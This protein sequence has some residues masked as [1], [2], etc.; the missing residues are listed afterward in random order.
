MVLLGLDASLDLADPSLV[1]GKQF[2][3]NLTAFKSDVGDVLLPIA[4]FT[5]TPGT[6]VSTEGRVQSFHAAVRPLGEARPAWK[7][8]RVLG[9]MLGLPGF[10]FETIEQVREACLGGRDIQGL[11][12]N[13]IDFDSRQQQGMISAGIQRVADVPIYFADPLARRSPPLQKTRDAQA[14]RAWMNSRLLQ[15]LGVQ[16]GGLVLVKQ[17]GG[18]AGLAAALDD[19]LP[20]DCVRIAAGHPS[21]AA[22]GA[23]FAALTLEKITSRQAA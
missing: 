14:P 4:P 7:V 3:V 9:T 18:E 15:K 22:L 8:L 5:E 6:F 23:P 21:T 20:D 10:E 11:L 13:K 12:S 16:A 1:K 19:K 2:I 17:N